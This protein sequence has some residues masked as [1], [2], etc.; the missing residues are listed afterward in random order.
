MSGKHWTREEEDYLVTNWGK[1]KIKTLCRNLNR[2]SLSLSQK[3]Y[4][5]GLGTMSDNVEG[6]TISELPYLVGVDYRNIHKTWI[7]AK[8]MKVKLINK[9]LATVADEELAEF[10]QKHP[11]LW[12]PS[13]CDYVYFSEFD[14]FLKAL[15]EEQRGNK[16][17]TRNEWTISEIHKM[18][19]LRMKGLTFTQIGKQLGRSKSSVCNKYRHY[20]GMNDE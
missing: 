19:I 12:I 3:A 17:R 1:L 6:I 2:N 18:K 9:S 20:Y 14:W 16:A 13:K 10:M 7:K 4:R 5:M 15:E 8:G 11:T